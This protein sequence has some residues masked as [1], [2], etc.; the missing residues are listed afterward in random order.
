[1]PTVCRSMNVAG[2]TD[3]K[4]RIDGS[5]VTALLSVDGEEPTASRG[6]LGT[7]VYQS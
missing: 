3:V 2:Y 5:R 6:A 4:L 7:G 1:M